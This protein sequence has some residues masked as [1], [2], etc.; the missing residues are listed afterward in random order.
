MKYFIPIRPQRIYAKTSPLFHYYGCCQLP[1]CLRLQENYNC[2]EPAATQKLSSNT[3]LTHTLMPVLP[4]HPTDPAK[5]PFSEFLIPI[6]RDIAVT[7]NIGHFRTQVWS[8]LASILKFGDLK[9]GGCFWT[10]DSISFP[11]G[12]AFVLIH[13]RISCRLG[14]LHWYTFYKSV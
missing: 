9:A 1:Q 13:R 5:Y 2:N 12:L 6:F 14:N 10:K 3:Q 11:S 4:S 8:H 7:D